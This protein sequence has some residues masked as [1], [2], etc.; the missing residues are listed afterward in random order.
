ME[1]GNSHTNVWHYYVEFSWSH[2]QIPLP[3]SGVFF[4]TLIPF[5]GILLE[6]C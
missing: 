5:N 1:V 4:L 6:F 3:D 2:Y